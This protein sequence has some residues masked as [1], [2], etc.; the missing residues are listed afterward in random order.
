MSNF[1]YLHHIERILLQIKVNCETLGQALLYFFL[2]SSHQ[3]ELLS[4]SSCLHH[5]SHPAQQMPI[6]VLLHAPVQTEK[7][8]HCLPKE[9]EGEIEDGQKDRQLGL[10][11]NFTAHGLRISEPWS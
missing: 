7:L 6:A 1:F 5:W 3:S 10:M 4:N 2:C 9:G 8:L 11:L